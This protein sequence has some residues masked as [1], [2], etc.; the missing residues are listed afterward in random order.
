MSLIEKIDQKY[1]ISIKEKDNNAINTLRLIKSAIQD[2]EISLRSKQEKIQDKDI[3]SLLQNMIKQRK[4][5][6][7]AFSKANRTDLI[8]KEESEVVIIEKFLPKQ[9]SIDETT[10][11]IEKIINENG[12]ASIKDMGKL[13]NI[14]KTN[15]AGEIDMGAAGNIAKFSLGK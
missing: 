5:S 14:I 1:K 9:L 8:K 7:E 13:M 2:K 3:L 10:K 6:I 4:D 15:Y 11:I 12:L